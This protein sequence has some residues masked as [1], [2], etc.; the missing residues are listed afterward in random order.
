MKRVVGWW[1]S[2]GGWGV[3]RLMECFPG[4]RETWA[5]R[6][7]HHNPGSMVAYACDPCTQ[8]EG[9]HSCLHRDLEAILVY[10]KI[11]S[12]RGEKKAKQRG[13]VNMT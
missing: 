13:Y 7:A 2:G 12:Q 5:Q 10:M 3:A 4:V 1:G 8:V 6:I 9:G 11:L